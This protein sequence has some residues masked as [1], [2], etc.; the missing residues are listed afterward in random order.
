MNIVINGEPKEVTAPSLHVLIAQESPSLP[1]AIAVNDQF[2]AKSDYAATILSEGDR[3][4][5]LS[6][7]SG[8]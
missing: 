5:I 8:G 4:E 7:M 1:F 2:V 6:P 3:V